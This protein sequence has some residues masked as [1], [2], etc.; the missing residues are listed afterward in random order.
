MSEDAVLKIVEKHKKDGDG[1]ISI[2]EDIQAKYSYLPDYALRTVADETGKSLVDIYGVATF[3]RYFSLKPKGKHLVNCCLGTACHVRGGQSIADEFQ[4]QLKI[5]PGETTPDNEFTFETV[6]CLGA[7]ALGPV[8]VVD[9]HYFS[10]VKTTKVKH[11]LEEA[12]KGLEAVR[13]EGDKRIFPVEVSCTKCN[14]TLMDNEV[15]IDNYPSIRLTISFKDKH[16][17]VR[18]SGMYGSYNI[19]S[20]YE[21]PEDTTVNFFCP[22][23]HAELKSPTICPDC[24]EYMI[25]LMLK[26]GGIVQVCPKRGCQGHLL[27]LF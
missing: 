14:H 17:S 23:C 22:H 20:E 6:N 3:Y 9:G 25:P 4:K 13:V 12:K 10:K 2:L 18:L 19:E 15:L 11:I 7:C 5:P 26:G 21:V 8:A 27:D 1:I 24:G 16:G